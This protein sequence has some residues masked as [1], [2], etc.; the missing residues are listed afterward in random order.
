MSFGPR[1]STA[2]RRSAPRRSTTW[3]TVSQ[4]FSIAAANGYQTADL[5]SNFK[6]DGGTQQG[7]TVARTHLRV[8]PTSA[9]VAGNNFHVGLIRGQASDVGVNIAGAPTPAAQPYEDWLLWDYMF[10]DALGPFLDSQGGT[11]LKYDLR[12]MRRLQELQMNYNMVI[13]VPA[14]SVFPAVFQ[15]TGRVLLK[16]P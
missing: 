11:Q 10:V 16:L 12:A 6:A 7:V 4:T 15:V 5:L 14:A 8:V 9:M 2:R 13:D 3:A 1:R